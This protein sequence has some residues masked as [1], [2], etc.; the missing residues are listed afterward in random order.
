MEFVDRSFLLDRD[1]LRHGVNEGVRPKTFFQT[2]S[3]QILRQLLQPPCLWTK[4]LYQSKVFPSKC[5][6]TIRILTWSLIPSALK[7]CLSL[8]YHPLKFFPSKRGQLSRKGWFT[9][10]KGPTWKDAPVCPRF[11]I[12]DM[13]RC[14]FSGKLGGGPP[15]IP[16]PLSE[17][18]PVIVAY[19]PKYC[20]N[21]EWSFE[22]S[23]EH[24]SLL[25]LSRSPSN[26]HQSWYPIDWTPLATEWAHVAMILYPSAF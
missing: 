26:V 5:S 22:R 20:S 9:T 21:K 10:S 23:L 7:Y 19:C 2:S 13:T 17:T 24:T 12:G 3:I 16:L 18:K 8:N 14:S 6:I 4:K 11:G 15:K 1:K 25:T